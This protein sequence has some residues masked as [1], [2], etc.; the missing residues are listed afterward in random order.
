MLYV[1]L[2]EVP[3]S[4]PNFEIFVVHEA[5][6]ILKDTRDELGIMLEKDHISHAN[7]DVLQLDRRMREFGDIYFRSVT[8]QPDVVKV[9]TNFYQLIHHPNQA[10][11]S[12]GN[13]F[14]LAVNWAILDSQFAKKVHFM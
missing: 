14:G 5:D 11:G 13:G 2:K 12:W 10:L 7:F 6:K 8:L 3:R 9:L 4:P 1:S